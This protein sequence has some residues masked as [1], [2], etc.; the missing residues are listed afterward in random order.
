MSSRGTCYDG[1]FRS[2]FP[3]KAHQDACHHRI[4]GK[5][6]ITGKQA[7]NE[8][9]VFPLIVPAE[10]HFGFNFFVSGIFIITRCEKAEPGDVQALDFIT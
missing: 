1:S 4:D 8:A 9:L 6:L 5:P 7:D 10:G 3:L 2:V